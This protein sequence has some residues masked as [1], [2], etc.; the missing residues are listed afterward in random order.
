MRRFLCSLALLTAILG[1]S[2]VMKADTLYTADFTGGL[3]F[4]TNAYPPFDGLCATSGGCGIVSGSF[5]F[6]SSQ[7]PAP[8]SGYYNVFFSGI[9]GIESIPAATA[10]NINLQSSLSFTLADAAEGSGAIQYNNG[11]FNGL[12]YLADFGYQGNNYRFDDE[13]GTFT[14]FLLDS[15]GEETGSGVASGYL[16]F[17]LTNVTPY[18]PTPPPPPAT[19]EPSTFVLLG[20]GLLGVVGAV[21]RRFLLGR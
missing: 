14:I 6:D 5:V 1:S 13:G 10:F 9:P 4:P 3:F 21:R 20:S 7:V 17:S 15:L 18:S 8:G 16:N 19:P 12:F 2:T 11:N